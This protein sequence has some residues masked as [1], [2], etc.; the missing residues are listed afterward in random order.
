MTLLQ[1]TVGYER[2]GLLSS[3][4][5]ELDSESLGA[6]ELCHVA[7]E[8]DRIL[9]GFKE[10]VVA[11]QSK[12][13]A[14]LVGPHGVGKTERLRLA[15][16]E[17]ERLSLGHAFVQVQPTFDG[18]VRDVAS[19][20]IAT[21]ELGAMEKFLGPP[22]WHKDLVRLGKKGIGRLLPEA[23]GKLV[24]KA[25]NANAPTFLLFNDL[26]ALT[27]DRQA[28]AFAEFLQTILL[29]AEPGLLVLATCYDS[30]LKEIQARSPSLLSRFH[31]VTSVERISDADAAQLVAKRLAVKRIVD[32]LDPT[33]PFDAESLHELN[34]RSRNNPRELLK[35]A[36]RVLDAAVQARAY[37]VDAELIRSVLVGYVEEPSGVSSPPSLP[38]VPQAPL[39]GEAVPTPLPTPPNGETAGAS[40]KTSAIIVQNGSHGIVGSPASGAATMAERLKAAR[41]AQGRD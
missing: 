2:F 4:F 13:S 3:P 18:I 10:Q 8:V 27:D 28:S 35:L 11:K 1:T 38:A 25:L 29:A 22:V 36:D 7:Q 26:Q 17:A 40:A 16:A 31:R 32:E 24:V 6:V 39:V 15:Q 34:V 5:N 30:H 14:L 20:L 23:A 19:G 9:H 12:A 37:H 33:F 21:M 41:R